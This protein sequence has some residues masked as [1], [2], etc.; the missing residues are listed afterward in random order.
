[1]ARGSRG[2]DEWMLDVADFRGRKLKPGQAT[3]PRAAMGG[4]S[5]PEPV[6]IP[7]S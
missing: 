5:P 6:Q 1:M 4:G 2:Y 7:L 3:G